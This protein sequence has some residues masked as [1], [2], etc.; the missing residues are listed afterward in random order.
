MTRSLP[1]RHDPCTVKKR[2]LKNAAKVV[3]G[4]SLWG[5][6]T[7][8]VAPITVLALLLMRHQAGETMISA[9]SSIEAGFVIL[10][11]ILG[12]YLVGS[13]HRR[14]RLLVTWHLF[15]IIPFLF[16]M[17]VFARSSDSLPASTIRWG[18]LACFGGY[19]LF[20][21]VIVAVWMDWMADL[22]HQGIRGSVF[23][24]TLAFYSLL[25][26]CG[27]L[28]SGGLIER[29]ARPEVFGWLYWS[30][31]AVGAVSM[32]VFATVD[33]PTRDKP[34]RTLRLDTVT[35]FDRIGHSL[36]DREFR[37]YL[38][39]RFFSMVGFSMLP[40]IAVY[41]RSEGGGGLSDGTIVA[42]GAALTLGSAGASFLLGRFGDKR[43]HRIG[44][45]V[46]ITVQVI[47]LLVLLTGS[48]TV[49]CVLVYA[50]AGICRGSSM[51]SGYNM[52]FETC[53]H[54]SRIAHIT[55]G[56]FIL[57]FAALAAPLGAGVV[58]ERWDLRTLFVLSLGFSVVALVWFVFRVKDPR[59]YR[60]YPSVEEA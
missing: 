47:T 52:M 26:A 21:G 24:T 8:L 57:A 41:F 29:V 49:G 5:F 33:D 51:V 38:I 16:L 37:S 1:T 40:F 46:G 50:G 60:A 34:D 11:Q 58:A 7:D 48:G 20:M 4:D 12:N 15:A 44:M 17:G 30:A 54:E 32:M 25:G 56:N 53:P 39:G 14:K 18:L 19:Y 2:D 3:T 28:L 59:T 27:S 13:V 36:R 22:F 31:G 6:Q 42:A 9:I 10:P 23:G 45:L 35:L 43:G 55:A